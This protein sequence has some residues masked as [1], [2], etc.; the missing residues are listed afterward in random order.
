MSSVG[1]RWEV[2]PSCGRRL[3]WTFAFAALLPSANGQ[4]KPSRVYPAMV[5]CA[6]LPCENDMARTTDRDRRMG[7]H[8][9]HIVAINQKGSRLTIHC[10]G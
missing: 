6:I 5:G 8:S 3:W 7:A 4:G 1:W 9:V 2:Q 10:I